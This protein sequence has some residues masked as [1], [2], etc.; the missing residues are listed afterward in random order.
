MQTREWAERT[1]FD[2]RLIEDFFPPTLS[3][4]PVFFFEAVRLT[5]HPYPGSKISSPPL[6]LHHIFFGP[7]LEAPRLTTHT[8]PG[9][10]LISM[11]VFN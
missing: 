1:R 4:H 9:P 10:Q 5:N 11:T 8:Y 6:S 2:S 3:L 7:F